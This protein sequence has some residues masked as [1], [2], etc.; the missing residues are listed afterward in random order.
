MGG[1]K[2][3]GVWQRRAQGKSTVYVGI[4]GS[5]LLTALRSALT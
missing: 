1:W 2:G 5:G 4:F 3:C